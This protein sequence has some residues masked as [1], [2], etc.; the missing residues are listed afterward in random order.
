MQ[1]KRCELS[2]PCGANA[3]GGFCVREQYRGK[4]RPLSKHKNTPKWLRATMAKGRKR[5]SNSPSCGGSIEMR[6]LKLLSVIAVICLGS[7]LKAE[8]RSPVK[9][10]RSKE[11][12]RL[13]TEVSVVYETKIGA[14]VGFWLRLLTDHIEGQCEE[15]ERCGTYKLIAVTSE[16][17]ESEESR[18]FQIVLPGEV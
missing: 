10:I 15:G 8:S 13:L 1:W 17:G 11:I 2:Q 7:T 6:S 9:E 16:F 5:T 12:V 14:K 3:S 4:L 18:A